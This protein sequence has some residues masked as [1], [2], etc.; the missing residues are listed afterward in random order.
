M[1]PNTILT[2]I[3]DSLSLLLILLFMVGIFKFYLGVRQLK[4]KPFEQRVPWYN[5]SPIFN[6]MATMSFALFA[7]FLLNAIRTPDL[8]IKLLMSFATVA[9]GSLYLL[10]LM[11]MHRNAT[12]LPP[13]R[14]KRKKIQP[15]D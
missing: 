14:V 5:Y 2:I 6:S 4:R 9:F 15:K 13:R 7:F 11:R 10:C 8:I 12:L 3:S 1:N